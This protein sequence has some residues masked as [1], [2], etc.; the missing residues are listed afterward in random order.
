MGTAE[1][2]LILCHCEGPEASPSPL[3]PSFL[4]SV[5][6]SPEILSLPR[7]VWVSKL[8]GKHSYISVGRNNMPGSPAASGPGQDSLLS[9]QGKGKMDVF[10]RSGQPG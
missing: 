9:S 4:P 10:P 6:R 5:F 8:P 1:V 3:S 7:V 2:L